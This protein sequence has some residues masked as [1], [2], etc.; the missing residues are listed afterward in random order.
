MMSPAWLFDILAALVLVGRGS[1]RDP[2]RYRLV[3]SQPAFGG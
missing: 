1:E 3:A 2:H